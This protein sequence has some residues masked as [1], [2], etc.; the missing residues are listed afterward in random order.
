M[1]ESKLTIKKRN[2]LKGTGGIYIVYGYL[3]P[4]VGHDIRKHLKG[5][6]DLS[7][8]L[9][10]QGV[11]FFVNPVEEQFDKFFAVVERSTPQVD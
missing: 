8:F 2:P 6:N 5:G 10:E 4:I 3:R 11:L 7:V 1:A 9:Y